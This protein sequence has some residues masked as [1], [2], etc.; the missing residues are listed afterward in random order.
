M[1]LSI[2]GLTNIIVEYFL[3]EKIRSLAHFI[4][5][6]LCNFWVFTM[7]LV[8]G[9]VILANLAALEMARYLP[10]IEGRNLHER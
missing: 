10:I 9:G 5:L 3:K 8:T 2:A 4:L 7:D 6:F 1:I